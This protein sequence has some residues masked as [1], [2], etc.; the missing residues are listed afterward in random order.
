MKKYLAFF[1]AVLI[2]CFLPS[3]MTIS[4]GSVTF[5]DVPEDA[6]YYEH[7]QYVAIILI[8]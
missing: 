2:L 4:T 3:G 5:K 6:W 8:N 1:L 7:V